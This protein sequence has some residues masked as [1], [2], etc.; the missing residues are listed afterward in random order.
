MLPRPGH[1]RGEGAD[2]RDEAGDDDGLA[3]VLLEELVGVGQVLRLDQPEALGVEDRR[4]RKCPDP[5][6]HRVAQDRGDDE[7]DEQPGRE[8]EPCGGEGPGREEQRVAGQ[9]RA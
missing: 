5:V 6:V 7:Q 9:E 1:E 4:P 2:D 3:A 8:S